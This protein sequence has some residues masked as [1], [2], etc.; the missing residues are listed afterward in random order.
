MV[1][2]MGTA[3]RTRRTTTKH[4]RSL[5]G[6]FSFIAD[7]H[8]AR[9][10]T[11]RRKSGTE[12]TRNNVSDAYATRRGDSMSR[13]AAWTA[14][15]SF[16]AMAL[17]ARCVPRMYGSLAA[18][19]L[20]TA[21]ASVLRTEGLATFAAMSREALRQPQGVVEEYRVMASPWGFAPEDIT[22]PLSVWAGADDELLD[23][24]WPGELARRIPGATLNLRAGGH[25]MAHLY[26]R[27]IFE[28]LRGP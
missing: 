28:S 4:P 11:L 19:D 14:R 7:A 6:A 9:G 13:S 22:V 26:Y 21:D 8:A 12:V 20:G 17:A 10:L 27:D 25:F 5:T 15:L 16:R 18:R 24:S 1:T 3:T 23:P 2:A